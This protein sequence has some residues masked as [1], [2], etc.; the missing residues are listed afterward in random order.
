METLCPVKVTLL[1]GFEKITLSGPDAKIRIEAD[2]GH[3]NIIAKLGVQVN[4]YFIYDTR[5]FEAV[6]RGYVEVFG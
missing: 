2:E 1:S 3:I 5:R 6:H 4:D